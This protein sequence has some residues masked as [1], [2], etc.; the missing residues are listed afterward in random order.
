M[1]GTKGRVVQHIRF[2]N[3]ENHYEDLETEGPI[4]EKSVPIRHSVVCS[5]ERNH[6]APQVRVSVC[7]LDVK[8]VK[9]LV[10]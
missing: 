4:E 6:D 7:I 9:G 10:N 5:R 2:M 3:R 1:G 8:H